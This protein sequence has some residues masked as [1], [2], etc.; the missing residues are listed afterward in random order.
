MARANK[1]FMQKLHAS[2]C[3]HSNILTLLGLC[4][5][6]SA[7]MLVYEYASNGSLEDYLK[8]KSNMENDSWAQRL[9]ICLQVARGLSYLHTS[10]GDRQEIVHRDIKSA[11]ILLDENLDAR[12]GDFGLCK[13][14]S[15]NEEHKGVA[16]TPVY[17]DPQY[18]KEG[19]LKKE[20]DIYSLGVVLIEI[21][22]GRLAYDPIYRSDHNQGLALIARQHFNKGTVKTMVDG[23]L[24]LTRGILARP[25]QESLFI[26][27]K[28]AYQCLVQRQ[29]DRP[30]IKAVVRQLEKAL[31]FQVSQCPKIITFVFS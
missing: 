4:D 6:G 21:L 25:N 13:F 19:K 26:F 18:A 27:S 14:L 31:H 9:N 8:K 17:M 3:K 2:S 15:V 24:E 11:N 16:G 12:I 10:E 20:L 1:G 5:E 23:R 22:C 30:T 29:E 28:L 7:M